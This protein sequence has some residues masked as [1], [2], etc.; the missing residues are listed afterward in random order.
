MRTLGQGSLASVLKFL[1]DA[2]YIGLWVLLALTSLVMV[3]MMGAA[4][5]RF[6]GIGPDLPPALIQFLHL[7]VVLA[8]P[9]AI[10][11]IIALTFIT[12]RLRRIFATLIAGD[13]FVPENAGHLR[14]IAVAI[15]VFQI[16]RYAAQGSIALLFTLAGRPVEG[17]T[18]LAPSFNLNV[19]AWFAVLALFVLSEVFREGAKLRQDQ[20]LT[21]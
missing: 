18:V 11:A 6:T 7:D 13:P 8:L 15:A 14:S 4:L 1:L 20:K 10:A 9:L 5:F 21:I 16:I 2:L 19:G 12:E 3:L 17:G